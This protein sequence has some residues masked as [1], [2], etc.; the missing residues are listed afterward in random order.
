MG[1][2]LFAG[3]GVAG[4]ISGKVI[5]LGMISIF[6][7]LLG[8]GYLVSY[9]NTANQKVQVFLDA[10][11]D[12]ESML[13]FPE[14]KNREQLKLHQAFNRANDLL[15]ELKLESR[16][17]EQLYRVLLQHIPAGVIIWN[18]Q[19]KIYE[20]NETVLSLLKVPHIVSISQVEKVIPDLRAR[21]EDANNN[22]M[23]MLK[24]IEGS[25][26]HQYTLSVRKVVLREEEYNILI[27]TDIERELSQKEFEAW[28]KLTHVLT[29]EIMNSIAP[30]VS[31]SGTLLSYFQTKEKIKTKEEISDQVL[32]KTVRGLD[33]IKKQGRS[34]MKFTESYRSLSFLQPS[35]KKK[36]L[37]TDLVEDILLLFQ[38][39]FERKKIKVIMHYSSSD[40]FVMA[41]REQIS[42]VLVNLVKNSIE[43]LENREDPKI[44]IEIVQD[45]N[46]R[47]EITDNGVGIPDNLIDDIFVP[48]FTTKET[49]SGVG[50]SLSRQIIRMHQGEIYLSS[51]PYVKTTVKIILPC[52]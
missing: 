22:G 46:I 26:I 36:F 15:S 39:D 9:L 51:A 49:G 1:I 45:T 32:A 30:V 20:I 23:S 35:D 2:I 52:S 3:L 50:L 28:N 6:I 17:Q 5:I 8:I 47:I 11:Q 37:L 27:L 12:N 38:S 24:I 7:S 31:L 25:V 33:T 41:D 29:H 42:H 13:F 40:L 21:I 14:K 34:L 16:K 4:I 43:A 44:E 19:G 18:S 48:F 10:L